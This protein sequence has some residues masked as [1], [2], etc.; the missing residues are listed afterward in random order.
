MGHSAWTHSAAARAIFAQADNALGYALSTLCFEGPD[1]V[2]RQTDKQQ[3]AILACSL[4]ILA[5]H[6]EMHG[7][8]DA[9]A[10]TG[11]SLGLYTALVAA[12]VL[13]LDEALPLVASRGAL[14]QKGAEAR[15]GGMAAVLGLDDAAVEAVCAEVSAEAPEDD[16]VV[17]ANYNAPGQVVIS[18]GSAALQRATILLKVR[19]ARKVVALP[20]AGAFHSPLMQDAAQELAP[21]LEEA[22]LREPAYPVYANSR[23]EAMISSADVRAELLRQVLA[24]VR[25]SH[26]VAAL[27]ATGAVSSYIDCGPSTTLAALQKRITPGALIVTLDGRG[28]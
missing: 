8:F 17:P 23:P 24:P 2:L 11:H 9:V 3:P 20:V 18:G 1:E 14:M 12:G 22:R 16:P 28:S 26:A 6:D 13:D 7:P 27:G 21:L 5:A 19:G 15:P 25:W 4:A 10:A